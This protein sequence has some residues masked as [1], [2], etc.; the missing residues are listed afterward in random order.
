MSAASRTETEARLIFIVAKVSSEYSDRLA[1]ADGMKD[2]FPGILSLYCCAYD[3]QLS[4]NI[5]QLLTVLIL[6]TLETRTVRSRKC[7]MG[8]IYS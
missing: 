1:E 6:P 4:H 2:G 3:R 7:L 8:E 5:P